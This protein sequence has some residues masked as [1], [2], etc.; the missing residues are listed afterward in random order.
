MKSS[1]TDN[2]THSGF[3]RTIIKRQYVNL[4]SWHLLKLKH[5]KSAPEVALFPSVCQ[6]L[7]MT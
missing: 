1:N 5:G 6:G 3:N 2:T 4:I 7:Q